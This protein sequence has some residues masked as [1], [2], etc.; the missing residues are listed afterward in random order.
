MN[1]SY[2]GR[3][4]LSGVGSGP[5]SASE[6]VPPRTPGLS[7]HLHT[8]SRSWA[9]RRRGR[10]RGPPRVPRS[11]VR[12]RCAVR[13]R[14]RP[15]W[16]PVRHDRPPRP[17]QRSRPPRGRGWG[18]VGTAPDR[19]PRHPRRLAVTESV[20]RG[21]DHVPNRR[22][23][24]LVSTGAYTVVIAGYSS[25]QRENSTR[26]SSSVTGV[27]RRYRLETRGTSPVLERR[28]RWLPDGLVGTSTSARR[29]GP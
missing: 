16:E 22:R 15:D 27:E 7:D 13:P 9:A 17:R 10:G 2:H 4:L 6:H 20:G 3:P 18:R 29:S 28:Y 5:L 14:L 12:S 23:E 24:D 26:P 25:I 21:K 19:R 8:H 1:R 11:S